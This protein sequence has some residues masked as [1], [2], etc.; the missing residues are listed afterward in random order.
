MRARRSGVIVTISSVSGLVANGGGA[1]YSASKFA[2]EGW[3]EGFGQELEPFGIQSLL[4]EPGMLRTDFMDRRSA[5][6]GGIDIPDYAAAVAEYRAF[7]DAA[8]GNQPGD[9]KVLA[10]RIL[11]GALADE[12]GDGAAFMKLDV[13]VPSEWDAAVKATEA[14]FGPISV[15]INDAGV[16]AP[17]VSIIDSEPSDWDTVIAAN[18]TGPYLGIRAVAPSIKRAGG[19]AIINIASTS[20]HV[21]TPMLAPYV[22][23]KWGLRGLTQTAAAELARDRIRVNAISPGVIN[24]PLITEPLRPGQEPVSDH[25]SPDPFAVPRMGEPEE[26]FQ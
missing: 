26:L 14:R 8:N 9:P 24:T 25:F 3:M 4:V 21:G 1:V 13:T 7:I 5:S 11:G 6:F 10:K 17:A 12:L 15:L 22:C 20:G 2:V 23:S 18:L 19:G 16:L